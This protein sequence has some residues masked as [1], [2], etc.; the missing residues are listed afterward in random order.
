MK[1]NKRSYLTIFLMKLK[2]LLEIL[3]STRFEGVLFNVIIVGII[4]NLLIFIILFK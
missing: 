3:K 1:K 2:P 4:L